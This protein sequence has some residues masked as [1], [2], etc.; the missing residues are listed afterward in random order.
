MAEQMDEQATRE[1]LIEFDLDEAVA[2]AKS[3]KV[4]DEH[5][6]LKELASGA[7]SANITK[8]GAPK[9]AEAAAKVEKSKAKAKQHVP[10]H[11]RL[12]GRC[13]SDTADDVVCFGETQFARQSKSAE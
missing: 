13:A 11:R 8:P 1:L 10:R 2:A 3:W 7:M 12:K 5:A 9:P 4:F 6:P